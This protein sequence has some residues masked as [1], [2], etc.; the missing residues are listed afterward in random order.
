MHQRGC[1]NRRFWPPAVAPAFTTVAARGRGPIL[2]DLSHCGA[3]STRPWHVS[4]SIAHRGH[5]SRRSSPAQHD[6]RLDATHLDRTVDRLTDAFLGEWIAGLH[7]RPWVAVSRPV[8]HRDAQWN[9]V[10]GERPATE[11][12]YILRA[13]PVPVRLDR[14][15]VRELAHLDVG[16]AVAQHFD[17]LGTGGGMP[18]AVDYEVGAEGTGQPAHDLDALLGRFVVIERDRGLCTEAPA[19]SEAGILGRSDDDDAPCTHLLGGG[20]AQHPDRS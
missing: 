14:A 13:Y 17:T 10:C 11:H 15:G 4:R 6:G 16:P 20:H 18:G 9:V 5:S 1:V 19:Q 3:L 7:L 2:D 12:G 8:Q